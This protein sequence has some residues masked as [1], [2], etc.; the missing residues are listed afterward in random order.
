MMHLN[1]ETGFNPNALCNALIRGGDRVYFCDACT[2]DDETLLCQQCFIASEHR[3]HRYTEVVFPDDEGHCD[4]GDPTSFTNNPCCSRHLAAPGGSQQQGFAAPMGAGA[5]PPAYGSTTVDP[6]IQAWFQGVDANG[7]GFIDATELAQ[8]LANG[9]GTRFSAMACHELVAMFDSRKSGNLDVNQFS[10]LF[11][12]IQ[13]KK[14]MFESF[15]IDRST[16]LNLDQ[17]GQAFTQLGYR[18]SPQFIQ[19]LSSKYGA[20]PGSRGVTLDTFII[21]TTQVQ[22]LTDAF[23]TRDTEMKGQATLMYEDF[24]GIATGATR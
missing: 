21:M 5:P 24:L 19:N 3:N 6:Q 13:Q 14:T 9:D 18:F 23:R 8:A 12:F 7:S 1:A 16:Y 2:T 10:A 17:L 15:D 4:C 22:R 11:G 20:P